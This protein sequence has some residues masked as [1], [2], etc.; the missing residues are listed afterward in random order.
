MKNYLKLLVA[1]LLL[2]TSTYGQVYLHDFQKTITLDN[3]VLENKT[4]AKVSDG[5]YVVATETVENGLSGKSVFVY[6]VDANLDMDWSVKLDF[7]NF[8]LGPVEGFYP[9][10]IIETTEGDFTICGR[11]IIEGNQANSGGFIMHL[12]EDLVTPYAF[13]WINIYPEQTIDPTYNPVRELTRIVETSSGYMSIGIGESSSGYIQN[14]VLG[15]DPLGN[16]L[17]SK[18]IIP[19]QYPG[20]KSCV[21]NDMVKM[22]DDM[23]AIVGTAN[24]IP[25]DDLDI[26]VVTIGAKGR[27]LGSRIYEKGGEQAD[28]LYTHYETGNTIIYDKAID[29]LLLVGTVTKK[30][31]IACTTVEFRRLLAMSLDP[32]TLIPNWQ[33]LYEIRVNLENNDNGIKLGE[34]AYRSDLDGF[35]IAGTVYN[36]DFSSLVNANG[37][38]L[39]CDPDG[40]ATD[41]RYYGNGDEEF[42]HRIEPNDAGTGFVTTGFKTMP[43]TESWWIESYDNIIDVCDE[44]TESPETVTYKT[45]QYYPEIK[46]VNVIPVSGRCSQPAYTPIENILCEKIQVRASLGIE[47]HNE[48][49]FEVFPTITGGA[50]TIAAETSDFNY[51]LYDLNGSILLSHAS[52]GA[53][54]TQVDLSALSNGIYFL[55]ISANGEQLESYKIIKQ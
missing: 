38:V 7:D 28:P 44:I 52:N 33:K 21:L 4:L 54:L 35:A 12:R 18:V 51:A 16:V 10:D 45:V 5:G 46:S 6:H 39:R 34:V 42:L 17:W 47:T 14:I 36:T 11:I 1:A 25:S 22:G 29:E 2:Q 9:H 50:V 32:N 8:G 19:T 27:L 53:T 31:R 41:I 13:D 49:D 55:V 30:I 24:G 23:V 26:V 15:T 3:H 43:Q 37:F 48:G 40:F 20:D